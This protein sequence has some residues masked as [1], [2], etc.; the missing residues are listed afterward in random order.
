MHKGDIVHTATGRSM[1]IDEA[2]AWLAAHRVI[3]VGESHDSADD[4]DVQLRILRGLVARGDR[5]VA[6]GLEMVPRNHQGVLDAWLAGTID[7]A[8]FE[9]VWRAG[10][11]DT[12]RYY[13]PLLDLAKENGLRVLALNAERDLVKAVRAQ[14]PEELAPEIAS[15]VPELDLDDPW[16]RAL[17]GA[18]FAGH[19]ADAGVIEGFYRAQVL[20]DE[21]MA[22][23]AS[24]FLAS[25]DGAEARLVIFAGGNHVRWGIGIPRRLFRRTPVSY[26]IVVPVTVEMPKEREAQL[27]DVDVPG[28]P[29]PIGDLLWGVGYGDVP[30]VALPAGHPR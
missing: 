8:A 12:L 6:I 20:W 13:R 17:I 27:M 19:A 23:T 5:P 7:D 28:M 4:H 21:T 15:R 26:A 22:D 18:F 3:Y 9:A 1:T 25:P 16:H 29:M 10:W 11:G 14:P 2:L 24:R 30:K